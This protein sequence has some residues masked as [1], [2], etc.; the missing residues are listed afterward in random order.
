MLALEKNAYPT[1]KQKL[2]YVDAGKSNRPQLQSYGRIKTAT[3]TQRQKQSNQ[4][5]FDY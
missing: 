1:P 3:P 2:K 4:Q 5:T